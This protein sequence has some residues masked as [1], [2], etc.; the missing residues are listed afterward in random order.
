MVR[1]D[2]FEFLAVEND[3]KII[4]LVFD[5]VGG[6][7]VNGMT[8]LERANPVNLNKL[9]KI[10]SCGR[11]IPVLWGI[12][13]GSGPAHFSLFGYDPLKYDV[14]RGILEALGIDVEVGKND[15]AVRGNFCTVEDGIVVDRRAGRIPTEKNKE[16]IEKLKAN[17]K[18]IDGVK[19]SLY[20]GKE[21]RFVLVLTHPELSEE[22]Q[23]ADPQK[24][25]LPFKYTEPKV[26]NE[27][28]KFTSKIVNKFLDRV[29]D[30]LKDEHPANGVLL[31]GFSLYPK[32]PPMQ[33]VFKLNP[34][35]IANYPMYRGL[36]KLVGM[37]VAKVGPEIEDEVKVLKEL[38]DKY[39]FF[40]L[41]IKKTDS[42]GED[43]NIERKVEIIKKV[44]KLL[45][46]ILSLK[47]DAIAVTGD[48][49]TP[50]LLKSHSWHPNPLLINSPYVLPDDVEK[51][52]EKECAKGILGN[53]Y[54]M[55]IVPLLLANT[56]K[57]KKYGA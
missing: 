54:S 18:E 33:K 29:L 14:G 57:L 6:L 38:W 45:P 28:A 25:G 55:D 37:E 42:Y 39:N 44:D 32:I 26:D 31:R 22:I 51:F 50:A 27:K 52:T 41:H 36:A 53:I 17:I 21:H 13:P 49:S 3:K 4:L 48:H 12:T 23:D 30:V 9:A 5:G 24:E 20:S 43:G 10:S 11:S 2:L 7:P 15:L 16:I 56:L 35:A 47:P 1:E 40:F 8:A 19:V 46:E 34:V